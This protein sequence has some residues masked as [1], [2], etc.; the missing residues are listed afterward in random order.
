MENN[1]VYSG[2]LSRRVSFYE[3]NSVK[4]A[5]GEV[6]ESPILIGV[7]SVKRID[8]AGSE[9]EDGRLLGLG[10]CRYQM[11]YSNLIFAK[12]STLSIT[13]DDGVWDVIG[14]GIKMDGRNRYM[15][16]KCRKRG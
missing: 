7:F 13:D 6:I 16:L 1:L 15:E 5:Q 3:Q 11:R 9:E 2:E 8:S 12:A 4:N 10:I 14:P